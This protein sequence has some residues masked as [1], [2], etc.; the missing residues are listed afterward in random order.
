MSNKWYGGCE[1][2]AEPFQLVLRNRSRG[3]VEERRYLFLGQLA[4][5]VSVMAL[6][7]RS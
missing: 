2:R 6:K 4:V 5:F 1:A 7:I 3:P